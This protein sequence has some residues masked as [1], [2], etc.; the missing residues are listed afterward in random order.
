MGQSTPVKF[1]FSSKSGVVVAGLV[2]VVLANVAP[3]FA[4]V[5]TA[6]P[7]LFCSPEHYHLHLIAICVVSSF[8]AISKLH[9]YISW[10][11]VDIFDFKTVK[12]VRLRFL[13]PA[14]IIW[15]SII[16]WHIPE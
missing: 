11:V 2:R 7:A 10:F 8:I 1:P 14:N 16:C 9:F 4:V 15:I 13:R 6:P 3:E 12:N 5:K